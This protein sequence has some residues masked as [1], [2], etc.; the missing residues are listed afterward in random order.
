MMSIARFRTALTMLVAFALPAYPA[1]A[2]LV[3]SQLV[4]DLGTGS[5]QRDDVEIW[6]N[7]DERTYVTIDPSEVL[8]AG[9]PNQARQQE[10][11]ANGEPEAE[12][13]AR[14]GDGD[15]APRRPP[16]ERPAT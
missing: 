4:V 15:G 5:R 1:R 2:E 10:A 14:D 3:L 9:K 12:G 6:N 16:V 13:K 7:S 8:N 11:T